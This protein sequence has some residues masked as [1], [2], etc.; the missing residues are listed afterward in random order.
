MQFVSRF[1]LSSNHTTV[2]TPNVNTVIVVFTVSVVVN[3]LPFLPAKKV[4]LFDERPSRTLR[5]D[6]KEV[7]SHKLR[8]HLQSGSLRFVRP[9][10]FGNEFVPQNLAS[11]TITNGHSCARRWQSFFHLSRAAMTNF[12]L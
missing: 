3:N 8:D 4:N 10:T 2:S 5:E 6:P 1:N 9:S 7:D 11:I 12:V